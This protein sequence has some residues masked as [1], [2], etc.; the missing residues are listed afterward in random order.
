MRGV[1]AD[2][3]TSN[4]DVETKSPPTEATSDGDVHRYLHMDSAE[5]TALL[6]DP[7]APEDRLNEKVTNAAWIPGISLTCC[8]YR[9][10]LWGIE[11]A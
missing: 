3:P 1:N 11:A 8:A 4:S 9:Q 2:E 5:L 10:R 6:C 7:R